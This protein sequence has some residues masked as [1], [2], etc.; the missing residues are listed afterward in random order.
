MK[1]RTY[2]KTGKCRL[3]NIIRQKHGLL[4]K[5]YFLKIR[6]LLGDKVKKLLKNSKMTAIWRHTSKTGH[7]M[8]IFFSKCT[9]IILNNSYHDKHHLQIKWKCL[10][11]GLSQQITE[12]RQNGDNKWRH[13]SKMEH[14]M[15]KKIFSKVSTDHA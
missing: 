15:K 9:L 4:C 2:W 12:K 7:D 14:D 1:S 3:C 8:E 5:Q 6:C 13:T 11:K 10:E